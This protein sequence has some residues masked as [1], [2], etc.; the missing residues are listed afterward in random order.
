MLVLGV[1]AG[2]V[3]LSHLNSAHLQVSDSKIPFP[4]MRH[5]LIGMDRKGTMALAR[6]ALPR[7]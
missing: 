1:G 6:R 5:C 3:I 7:D 2:L 4:G